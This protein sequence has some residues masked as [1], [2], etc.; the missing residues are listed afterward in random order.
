MVKYKIEAT[1]PIMMK[2][3]STGCPPTHVRV[4]RSATKS[5]NRH[6]L[7]GRNIMLRCL[8]VWRSGMNAKIRMENTR[9]STP[10]NLL[11]MDRRIA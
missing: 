8:D 3:C 4:R 9:A 1:C 7:R 10:P 6:W 11:G 2:G 5:Q